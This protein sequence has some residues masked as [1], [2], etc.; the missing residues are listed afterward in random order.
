MVGL[1]LCGVLLGLLVGG[2]VALGESHRRTQLLAELDFRTHGPDVPD[3]VLTTVRN[4][5]QRAYNNMGSTRRAAESIQDAVA[6]LL[7]Q[8]AFAQDFSIGPYRIKASTVRSTVDFA[9][10]QGFLTLHT[11]RSSR[12]NE[13]LP[14]FMLQPSINDWQAGVLLEFLRQRHPQ[15]RAMTWA[16]IAEDPNAI[17]KL[18]SG[19]MGA[20][21]DW[22]LWE[23][24]LV[25]GPVSRERLGYNAEADTYSAIVPA[26]AG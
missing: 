20:G 19:Y 10:D 6:L 14:L 4:A 5:E 2:L 7:P 9:L 8:L 11:Q 25:P 3:N 18:Y 24:D 13:V 12:F 15:L 22:A 1:I 21:G 16:Q 26:S 23:A 17:A